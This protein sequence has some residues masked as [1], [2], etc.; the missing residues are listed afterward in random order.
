MI[1]SIKSVLEKIKLTAEK[2][3]R[4]PKEITLV[5]VTKTHPLTE[6]LPLLEDGITHF[7]ENRLE[8]AFE[9]MEGA[10]KEI[11]WHFIGSLQRKKVP[12][13]I[14]RFSLIQSVDSFELAEKIS[15]CS[16]KA[17]LKTSILIQVNTSSELSKHGF[18]PQDLKELFPSL[19]TLEGVKIEGLMTMAPLTEDK[20]IIRKTFSL[21]R[22]LKEELEKVHPMPHLSM[23]MSNDFEM[24]IEEGATLLRIGTALFE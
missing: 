21:L 17:S 5:A 8:E 1:E 12:K 9:K 3:G 16:L 18:K 13:I 10:P 7:G 20:Q 23:G 19:L 14:G 11:K 22:E 6:C 2:S 15:E 4:S 24:A